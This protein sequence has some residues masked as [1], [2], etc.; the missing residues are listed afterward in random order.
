MKKGKKSSLTCSVGPEPIGEA[1][2][3]Y[4]MPDL[5]RHGPRR[6]SYQR[7][8]DVRERQAHFIL[9]FPSLR[10]GLS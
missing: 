5:Q 6:H 3:L 7:L 2:Q 4:A 10:V 8:I 1:A 9:E